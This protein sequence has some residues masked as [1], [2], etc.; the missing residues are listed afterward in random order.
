[1]SIYLTNASVYRGQGEFDDKAVV[2]IGGRKIKSVGKTAIPRSAK[3]AQWRLLHDAYR[4]WYE[5]PITPS[6]RRPTP[7]DLGELAIDCGGLRIYP[8]LLDPHTH[9]GCFEDGAGAVGFHGNEYSDPNTAHLNIKDSINPHDLAIPEVV[10]AGV[11][12]AGIF[13]GSANLIGGLCIACKMYGRTIDEMLIDERQGLKM[14]LGENP[15]RV[16]GSQNKFPGT[17]FGCARPS[18]RRCTM[19]PNTRPGRRRR[20]PTA[21]RSPGSATASWRTSPA[22]CAASTRSAITP[23][24]P[25]TST[26]RCA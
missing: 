15:F 7:P 4:R 3:R 16:Y 22:P 25:T 10:A 12:S 11:T 23:I 18:T 17:R 26:P 20:R 21:T 14:A 8:G 24:E 6:S 13:P 19:R 9:I 5:G 2:V 1:M